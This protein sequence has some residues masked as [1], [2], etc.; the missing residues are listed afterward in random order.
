MPPPNADDPVATKN[1]SKPPAAVVVGGGYDDVAFESM[2]KAC[3]GSST[4]PWLRVDTSKPAPPL[5]PEYGNVMVERLR[6]V[7]KDVA[8][9]MDQDGV[10]LF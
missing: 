8:D 1:F 9:K 3:E 7:L 4:I 10:Y 6:G 2:R 5:G